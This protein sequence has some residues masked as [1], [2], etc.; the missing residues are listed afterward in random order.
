MGCFVLRGSLNCVQFQL[1]GFCQISIVFKNRNQINTN[2]L[3]CYYVFY[4]V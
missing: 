4:L 3:L 2:S 1:Y